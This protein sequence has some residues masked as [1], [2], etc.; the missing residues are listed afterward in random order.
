MSPDPLLIAPDRFAMHR[1][2]F[3]TDRHD[4]PPLPDEAMWR[5]LHELRRA[6]PLDAFELYLVGSR[7]ESARETA[8]VDLILGPRAGTPFSDLRIERALW[9]CRAYGLYQSTPACLIDPAFRQEGP[10]DKVEALAP[11]R[12]LHTTRLFSPKLASLVASGRIVR[13][14]RCGRFS[15]E[16][17]RAAG[18]TSFY[19]KLPPLSLDP[20]HRYLRPAIHIPHDLS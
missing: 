3:A 11:E 9:L 2:L 20:H 7:V 10:G 19:S 8:D 6:P 5:I 4:L 16:Y 17:W 1:Y 13:Y 15:I 18:E 12:I 14:R